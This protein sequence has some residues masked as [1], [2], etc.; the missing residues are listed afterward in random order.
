MLTGRVAIA[1]ETLGDIVVKICT[2]PLPSLVAVVPSLPYALEAWFHKACAREAGDRY[3]SAQDFID[4]LR[5]AAGAPVRPSALSG[6][7]SAPTL[8]SASAAGSRTPSF[9]HSAAVAA[10]LAAPAATTGPAL[11]A[12]ITGTGGS[13]PVFSQSAAPMSV[14]AAG[15]PRRAMSGLAWAGVLA[16]LLAVAG[17]V[18]FAVSLRRDDSAAS[19]APSATAPVATAP[20]SAA[21][22][23]PVALVPVPSVAPAVTA[24]DAAS[25]AAAGA[26]VAVAPPHPT[27]ALATAPPPVVPG[28]HAP[29]PPP[30]P[31]GHTGKPIV[32]GY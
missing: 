5:A 30:T 6:L 14:T 17:A 3:P 18:V 13:P 22:T 4:A 16:G 11:L 26:H 24:E 10:T 21:S 1:G 9:G 12:A 31:P 25:Q 19:S 27:A 15:V 28:G 23:A 2:H 8:E 32:V 29:A 7:P 20:A